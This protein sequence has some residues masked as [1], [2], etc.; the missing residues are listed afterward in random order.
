MSDWISF[1]PFPEDNEKAK[2]SG[3]HNLYNQCFTYWGY[4]SEIPFANHTITYSLDA[5]G[6]EKELTEKQKKFWKTN[7]FESYTESEMKNFSQ[8]IRE[9]LQKKATKKV[10]AQLTDEHRKVYLETTQD[11]AE[12]LKMPKIDIKSLKDWDEWDALSSKMSLAMLDENAD[13]KTLDKI[14][15]LYL[16]QV[17]CI[18]LKKWG[19]F[20]VDY[21]LS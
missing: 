17:V 8:D 20:M 12:S 15:D 19:S 11:L 7:Q 3:F 10:C 4:V 14:A 18:L 21:E 5:Q 6:D 13:E 1:S 2:A 9:L 16:K